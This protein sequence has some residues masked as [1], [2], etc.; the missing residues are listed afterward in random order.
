M[1]TPVFT[2][3]AVALVTPFKDNKVDLD[4]LGE[5]IEYHIQNGTDAIVV[6]A[7]TGESPTQNTPE[8]M[9]TVRYTVE[10]AAGR[11]KIIAGTGSNDTP[12]ALYMCQTAE[13]YGVDGLLM[14]TP[15]YNKTSQ[16]G[17]VK[18]YQYVADR[19]NTPIILY[20]VPSR[21]GMKFNVNTYVE[22][23]KHPMIVGSKES[24]SDMGLI[25]G[26]L[27]RVNDGDFY[28]WS[29]ND[30]ETVPI[31]SLGG[32]GVISVLANIM[33]AETK[34]MCDLALNGDFASAAKM[35]IDFIKLINALFI[36]VNPVP[37]KTAMNLMGFNVGHLR[38][39]LFDMTEEHLETLKSVLREYGLLK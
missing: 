23:A 21:T 35:Q 15:Y 29:G 32:K 19:V 27:A 3:S 9:A 4:K 37:I 31:M 34:K 14:V 22:L 38:M 1:K 10:K 12:H 7:T 13:G 8:H 25:A 24:S 20:N 33:P 11:I 18:H 30:E 6:C 26:T 39:P 16:H 28:F 36:E 5:L 17:L 2:G